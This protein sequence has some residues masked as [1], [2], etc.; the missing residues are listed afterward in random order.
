ML[1]LFPHVSSVSWSIWQIRGTCHFSLSW[2]RNDYLP[3][4]VAGTHHL[5]IQYFWG[6]NDIL[7]DSSL[8]TVVCKNSF[9]GLTFRKF[10]AR[11]LREGRT[12]DMRE[13]LF[14]LDLRSGCDID[15]SHQFMQA[16][17]KIAL[18]VTEW[19]ALGWTHEVARVV[20][21]PRPIKGFEYKCSF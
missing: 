13:V 8:V 3:G 7:L 19:K 9:Y 4:W 21:S 16:L 10:L 11:N 12:E 5:N 17:H 14:L 2:I 6:R 20:C 15:Y 1:T 18:I